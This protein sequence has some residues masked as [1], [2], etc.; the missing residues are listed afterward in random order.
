MYLFGKDS[1]R[2]GMLEEFRYQILGIG[3]QLGKTE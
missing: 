3:Y 2:K 1:L